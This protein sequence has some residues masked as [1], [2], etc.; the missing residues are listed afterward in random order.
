MLEMARAFTPGSGTQPARSLLLFMAVGSEEAWAPRI[1][2][3]TGLRA[4]CVPARKPGGDA[5]AALEFNLDGVGWT[6]A[7]AKLSTTPDI[8]AGQRA[9]IADPGLA[10]AV[11][12]GHDR[13]VPPM[14]G[15]SGVAGGAQR[16]R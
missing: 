7:A 2:S 3:A 8:L 6:P 10:E 4:P 14:P 13:G 5:Q 15:T 12:G 11:E 1:R 9:V 16:T